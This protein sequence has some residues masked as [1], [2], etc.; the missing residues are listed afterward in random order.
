MYN[1]QKLAAAACFTLGVIPLLFFVFILFQPEKTQE[2]RSAMLGFLIFAIPPLSLGGAL[3]WNIQRLQA[4]RLHNTFYNLLEKNRGQIGV[5]NFAL[6]A[7]I[8]AAEAQKYLEAQAKAFGADFD[9]VDMMVVYRF[10]Y[11]KMHR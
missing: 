4:D 2:D 7:K 3:T 8:P 5:M 6:A 9:V 1:L 10:P 11:Q